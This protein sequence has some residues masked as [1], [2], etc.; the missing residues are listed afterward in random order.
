MD[1]TKSIPSLSELYLN[2]WLDTKTAIINAIQAAE[3]ISLNPLKCSEQ[4]ILK[5]TS[6]C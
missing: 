1:F 2:N 4:L 3:Q 6:G 5:I